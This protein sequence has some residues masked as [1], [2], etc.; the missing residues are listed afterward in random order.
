MNLFKKNLG[1]QAKLVALVVA[2]MLF[3]SG[4]L[5]YLGVS[6][7]YGYGEDGARRTGEQLTQRHKEKLESLISVVDT[8][9]TEYYQRYQRGELTEEDAQGR[10]MKRIS[11]LRYDEGRGYFWIH[12]A[13]DPA[14]PVMVMHPLK[15][16]MNGQDL[17]AQEDFTIIKSLFYKNQV[18]RK[19][20]PLIQ[21]EVKPTR[22]FVAMNE[23]C[24]REGGG[25]V[26][27]Y[28][29]KPGQDQTVGYPKLSYVK[30]FKPWN[31]VVG[32]GFYVDDVD[33][34]VAAAREAG[35]AAARK[36]TALMITVGAILLVGAAGVTLF[37]VR[38]A[39]KPLQEMVRETGRVAQGDLQT[40]LAVKTRDEVGALAA[41]FNAMVEGLRQ[42]VA[43]IRE[44]AAALAAHAHELAASAEETSAASN[45]I[46]STAG[47]VAS[48][49]ENMAEGAK[50]MSE[51]AAAT[52][53]QADR[54][55]ASL[56]QIST[57]M[58]SINKASQDVAGV[59]K[60][61]T[62]ASTQI[63]SIV[64]AITNIADQTNLLALNAAIEAARAGEQGRGFAVVAEEVR[65]LAEQSA[66]AAR[67]IQGIIARVQAETARAGEA[68]ELGLKEVGQGVALVK[69]VDELFGQI[70]D[71]VKELTGRVQE[72]ARQTGEVSQAVQDIA[73]TTEESTAATQ[74][75]ASSTE[76]LNRMAGELQGLVERFRV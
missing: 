17:S 70:I 11:S 76:A 4:T 32:T 28:W 73:G 22:L 15:P 67:E 50:R 35:A 34:E 9:L 74:E 55:R 60:E 1:L 10:A 26:R 69:S 64:D 24:A 65:K 33:R 61:L 51:V 48:T 36:T 16:E 75:L 59:V 25:F 6:R 7:I 2:V 53:G 54:G 23:V 21:A 57:Q 72:L 12:S 5:I 43:G 44:K 56:K 27:Y 42:V 45:E 41:S 68:M 29:P 46:A 30:L 13:A 66:A 3:L 71:Q 31:W 49:V 62:D 38:R 40:Q 63:G 47:E 39:L 14:R 19:E 8:L 52:A 37:F 18:Y 58:T 20:D